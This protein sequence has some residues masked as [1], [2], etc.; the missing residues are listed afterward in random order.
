MVSNGEYIVSAK[1]TSKA[2]L[3]HLDWINAGMPGYAGGGLIPDTGSLEVTPTDDGGAIINGNYVPPG[4]PILQDP[5]V[6]QA[7][8]KAYAARGQDDGGRRKHKSDFVGLF[9]GHNFDTPGSYAKGGAVG[10][11]IP[12]FAFGGMADVPDLVGAAPSVSDTGGGS[13][14]SPWSDIPHLGSMDW[15]SHLGQ[16]RVVGPAETLR[17]MQSAARDAADVQTGQRPTWYRGRS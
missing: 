16:V 14:S 10:R 6:K 1:G 11:G 7:L 13:A 4:S 2:G 8:A 9:G 3:A 15:N 17:H 5:R 12:H